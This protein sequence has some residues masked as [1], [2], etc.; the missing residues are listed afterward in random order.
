MTKIA[1]LSGIQPTRRAVAGAAVIDGGFAKKAQNCGTGVAYSKRCKC[2]KR[3]TQTLDFFAGKGLELRKID[4]KKV[5]IQLIA[6]GK[7]PVVVFQFG[8]PAKTYVAV[9]G[10]DSKAFEVDAI[11]TKWTAINEVCNLYEPQEYNFSAFWNLLKQE[12]WGNSWQSFDQPFTRYI[13]PADYE[14][15]VNGKL[16]DRQTGLPLS[17]STGG[18][19]TGT[20][21]GGSGTT[22]STGGGNTN[23]GL[24]FKTPIEGGEGGEGGNGED[25]EKKGLTTPQKI[26]IGVGILVAAGIAAAF[27]INQNR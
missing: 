16:I 21:G 11:R 15:D 5:F 9:K 2:N 6:P 20:T 1:I 13:I 12:A 18:T 8:A 23:A 24:P 17:A 25:D 26:G 3:I 14:Q 10:D 27:F 19:S 4:G 22:G 7:V